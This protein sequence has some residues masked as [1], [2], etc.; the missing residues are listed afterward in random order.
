MI[1]FLEWLEADRTVLRNRPAPEKLLEG[2]LCVS[3]NLEDSRGADE[4]SELSSILIHTTLGNRRCQP[5]APLKKPADCLDVRSINISPYSGAITTL[6]SAGTSVDKIKAEQHSGLE[7]RLAYSLHQ[8]LWNSPDYLVSLAHNQMRTWSRIKT[9]IH[10]S[11]TDAAL[12]NT[13]IEYIATATP[14]GF[15]SAS[16]P[17]SA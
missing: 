8:L 5:H 13:D 11:L 16:K 2:E 10:E 1:L 3:D 7:S 12:T 6:I 15:S 17:H 9:C 4:E 14:A